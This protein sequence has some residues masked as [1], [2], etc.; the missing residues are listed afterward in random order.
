MAEN[1]GKKQPRRGGFGKRFQPG[2][3][4]NPKGKQ[5]G[6]KNQVTLLAERLMADDAESV[7][8]AVIKAARG[9]DMLP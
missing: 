8:R 9:G 1:A 7:V 2:Q 6:C 3:S 5:K 4:G